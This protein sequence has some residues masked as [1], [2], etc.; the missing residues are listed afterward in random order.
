MSYAGMRRRD[1]GAAYGWG[2]PVG[3]IKGCDPRTVPRAGFAAAQDDN[4]YGRLDTRNRAWITG[5]GSQ[6]L[7]VLSRCVR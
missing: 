2:V 1:L 4:G 6:A 5:Y 7:G 3:S